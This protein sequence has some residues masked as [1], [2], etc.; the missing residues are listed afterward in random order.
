MPEQVV[1]RASTG[2]SHIN[3]ASFQVAIRA[4]RI[5]LVKARLA[6]KVDFL[7]TAVTPSKSVIDSYTDGF[8]IGWHSPDETSGLIYHGLQVLATREISVIMGR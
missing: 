7:A 8:S 6:G 5:P 1:Y 3:P 2:I 4:S